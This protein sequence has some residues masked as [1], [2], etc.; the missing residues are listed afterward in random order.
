VHRVGRISRSLYLLTAVLDPNEISLLWLIVACNFS[1]TITSIFFLIICHLPHSSLIL[2]V[3]PCTKDNTRTQGKINHNG[4]ITNG[5]MMP[6]HI[7]CLSPARTWISNVLCRGL[8]NF[9]VSEGERWEVRGDL[10]TKI[11]LI[12]RP[13]VHNVSITQLALNTWCKRVHRVGRISRSFFSEWRWEV[14]GERWFVDIGGIVDHHCLTCILTIYS[15]CDTCT[16]VFSCFLD[17]TYELSTLCNR[18]WKYY[19]ST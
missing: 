3:S 14:R 8:L 2:E 12:R 5:I 17:F 15:R 19:V 6:R 7:L 9:S 10:L 4:L 18:Y 11:K 13:L 1:D 16:T